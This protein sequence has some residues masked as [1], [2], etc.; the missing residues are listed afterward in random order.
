[1]AR[2]GS[3]ARNQMPSKDLTRAILKKLF[4]KTGPKVKK[5]EKTDQ[6]GIRPHILLSVR[7]SCSLYWFPRFVRLDFGKVLEKKLKRTFFSQPSFWG[8]QDKLRALE[9]KQVTRDG[10]GTPGRRG[11]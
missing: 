11:G 3:V 4:S 2:F 8:D 5:W 6:N 7:V 9:G 1:M 10:Q